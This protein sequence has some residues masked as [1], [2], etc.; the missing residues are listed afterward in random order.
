MNNHNICFR[1]EKKYQ[2]IMV[3]KKRLIKDILFSFEFIFHIFLTTNGKQKR[4]NDIRCCSFTVS[5]K[6]Y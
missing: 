4:Q 5:R 6:K 3:E 2:Y 1:G